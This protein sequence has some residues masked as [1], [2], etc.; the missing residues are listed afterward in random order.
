MPIRPDKDISL[1]ADSRLLISPIQSIPPSVGPHS[2]T[3]WIGEHCGDLI[4]PD[5]LS[6]VVQVK[7]RY[8]G[9]TVIAAAKPRL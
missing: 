9:R 8:R 5:I 2:G 7:A 4:F 1:H 3:R 6:S